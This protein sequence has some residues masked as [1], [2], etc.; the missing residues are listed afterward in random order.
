MHVP[1]AMELIPSVS[2]SV[3]SSATNFQTCKPGDEKKSGKAGDAGAC[4][5]LI[6]WGIDT[7]Q[8]EE[9]IESIVFVS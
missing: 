9:S 8:K 4:S 5:F 3:R 1:L 7:G 2:V 6:L